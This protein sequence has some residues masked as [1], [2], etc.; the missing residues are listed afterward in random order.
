MS[1]GIRQFHRVTG[2]ILTVA[3]L[4][5]IAAIAMKVQAFWIGLL[6]LIPLL[7]MMATGLY[8]FALPYIVKSPKDRQSESA[9]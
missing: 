6:A 4:I 9:E 5:N 1:N 2:I 7:A 8:L 3:V